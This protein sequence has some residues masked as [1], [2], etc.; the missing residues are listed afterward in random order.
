MARP[1]G[2][3][4]TRAWAGE[5]ARS[6]GQARELVRLKTP[7][8]ALLAPLLT[9]LL[10]PLLTTLIL[11]SVLLGGCAGLPPARPPL[12][13]GMD[14]DELLSEIAACH[15]LRVMQ[16]QD[17]AVTDA[18]VIAALER[19]GFEVEQMVERANA[20]ARIAASRPAQHEQMYD[21]ARAACDHLAAWTGAA[22]GLVRFGE[23]GGIGKTW[24]VVDGEIEPGFADEAIARLRQEKAVGLII[25]SPGG[26]LYEARRLGRWLR[27]NGLPVGVDELCTSACVDVLAGGIERYVT[28]NARLGIHQSRVPAHLSSHE[29]GQLSV[30]SAVLYL[31]EMGIDSSIALAA[32]AVP[33]N[34]MYWISHRE[35]LETGLV[36]K[37]IPS[38]HQ[39]QATPR[40]SARLPDPRMSPAAPE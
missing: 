29:G 17:R 27:E 13:E 20:L 15:L 21:M 19:S 22:S 14:A 11:A 31:R 10:A 40:S 7:L 24:L 18:V 2:R 4:Q 12:P 34:A 1:K 5:T 26:S 28:A 23:D 8:P 35:A 33:N 9:T 30:V 38:F 37:V 6:T 16:N 32:A 3:A 36:T 39:S 25:N